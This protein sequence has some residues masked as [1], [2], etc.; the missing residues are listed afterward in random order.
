LVTV[1]VLP[2]LPPTIGCEI[3]HEFVSLDHEACSANVPNEPNEM[4]A[5]PPA[6]PGAIHA[7]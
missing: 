5:A 7:H 3:A 6:C 2:V 4:F 1:T